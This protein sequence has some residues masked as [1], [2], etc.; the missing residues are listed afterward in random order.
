MSTRR[1]PSVYRPSGN[2]L[3]IG[4]IREME[5]LGYVLLPSVF[6]TVITLVREAV[7]APGLLEH[8]S[9]E[10]TA[11][12]LEEVPQLRRWL[13]EIASLLP[14]AGADEMA[15]LQIACCLSRLA[16]WA[17]DAGA[18]TTT[19]ALAEAAYDCAPSSAHAYEV[20]RV[21]QQ[22]GEDAV[23]QA[24]WLHE[25]ECVNEDEEL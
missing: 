3:H 13:D 4:L 1:P 24:W 21:A 9:L 17:E 25:A 11:L 7:E 8:R 23:E 16:E 19:L 12:E 22:N 20:V 14:A 15:R 10:I 6:A 18:R 2:P 5:S